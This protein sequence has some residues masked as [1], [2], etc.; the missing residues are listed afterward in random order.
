VKLAIISCWKY[1]DAWKP[2]LEV[3]EH[4]W[5]GHPQVYLLT[6]HFENLDFKINSNAFVFS[7]GSLSYSWCDVLSRFLADYDDEPVLLM[8]EDF[9]LTARVNDGLVAAAE[10]MLNSHSNIGAVRL[11]PCPGSNVLSA[12]QHWGLVS[13]YTKY[14]ISCQATIWQPS[15]LS[16]IA[17]RCI[18]VWDFENV[19][20]PYADRNLKEDVWAFKRDIQPWPIEYLCS[21][22]SRGLWNPDS[23]RLC[24]RLGI[25]A[26]WTMRGMAHA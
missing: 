14:R 16:A 13:K 18:T 7:C 19:G 3:L 6:D 26:D 17:A 22:I 10:K 9:F 25:E 24:D 2:F 11:Y 1:R 12:D 23:K 5:P 21:G 4:Y 8:Q 20:S 15:F